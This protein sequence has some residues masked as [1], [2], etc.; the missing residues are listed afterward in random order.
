VKEFDIMLKS[1]QVSLESFLQPYSIN[2]FSVSEDESYLVMGINFAGTFN[3]WKMDLTNERQFTQL[4]HNH[5]KMESIVSKDDSIYFTSDKNGNENMHIYAVDADG[6]HWRDIRTEPGC[7]YF[8]GGVSGDGKK[9]YYTSTKDNPIYL[10]IFSYDVENRVEELLHLGSGAE[11]QL[12][13]ISPNEQDFAYFVRHNHSHMKLFVKRNGEDVELIPHPDQHYRTSDLC[14]ID[15][16]FALF[17]TNYQEEFTY[18]ASY[19]FKSGLFQKQLGIDKQDI[20]KIHYLSS[21]EVVLQT[22]SGPVDRLYKYHFKT[23]ELVNLEIPTYTIQDYYVTSK[24]N[25][26]MVGSSSDLPMSLFRKEHNGEWEV[27]FENNVANVEREELILPERFRYQSFD[28]VEIEAMHYVAKAEN[29]NGYTIVYSHGGPQ[30]NEPIDYYGFFQYL[31]QL[32]FNIF[33]PNFRG[34][35]NYGT[36]FLK[37]IERDWG[38]GPR[39]DIL[40]GVDTLIQQGKAEADK[41]ILFGMSYGGYMSLLL[42]GRHQERFA[43]CIDICGPTN[44]FTLIETCPEHWTE[45]MHSWIGHPVN[46]RERLTE[47]SPIHYVASFSKPVLIIQG[48]NDPRVR[49]SES[50]QMVKV[51]RENGVAVEYMVFEDEGHG[52]SK[53]E[54]EISAYQ[55]VSTFLEGIVGE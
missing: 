50:D 42:F 40:A 43:G 41:M 15:E 5:Q 12:L 29:S 6:N 34:T 22:K 49:K 13:S 27:L 23:N 18:L 26:Y 54:N 51:M 55:R 24:G 32:G 11:T 31:L 28:G 45:R 2:T 48:A 44:L 35:P 21:S 16:D 20:E 25:V 38:G 36:S 39:E 47:Q 7:R 9:L 19:D 3:L 1:K 52:F 37:M 17:T 30:F 8:F 46:D 10:S 4:S 33:A 53:K 14:F